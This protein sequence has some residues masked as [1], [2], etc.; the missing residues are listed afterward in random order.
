LLWIWFVPVV[1]PVAIKPPI[2]QQTLIQPVMKA[3]REMGQISEA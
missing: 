2:D 1:T 3:R